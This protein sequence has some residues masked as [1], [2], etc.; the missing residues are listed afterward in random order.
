[1]SDYVSPVLAQLVDEFQ[2]FIIIFFS[3]EDFGA[4]LESP[5]AAVAHFGI[6]FNELL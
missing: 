2:E 4:I 5:V 1:M 3:P 6:S